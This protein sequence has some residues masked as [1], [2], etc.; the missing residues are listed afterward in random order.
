MSV[1]R[2]PTGT[3]DRSCQLMMFL[4]ATNIV[5][6]Q[7]TA[8]T[9]TACDKIKGLWFSYIKAHEI[10]CSNNKRYAL[11]HPLSLIS[12]CCAQALNPNQTKSLTLFSRGLLETNPR[13]Q[14]KT[15]TLFFVYFGAQAVKASNSELTRRSRSAPKT[16]ELCCLR[17][18]NS[19]CPAQSIPSPNF[20]VKTSQLSTPVYE[21]YR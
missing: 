8:Q 18:Y 21:E 10:Q 12:P 19:Q 16:Q 4:V 13:L 20:S 11:E 17:Y 14:K 3:A 6:G 5:G 9:L 7:L 1:E 15:Q 2:W